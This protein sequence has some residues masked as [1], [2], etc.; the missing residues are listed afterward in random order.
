MSEY[1]KYWDDIFQRRSVMLKRGY[2]N[3][4]LPLENENSAWETY[5]NLAY[6]SGCDDYFR[7]FSNFGKHMKFEYDASKPASVKAYEE[8]RLLYYKDYG[9]RGY[10]S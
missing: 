5:Y 4:W 7:P 6:Y 3:N 2:T 1:Y 10:T 8:V 9:S